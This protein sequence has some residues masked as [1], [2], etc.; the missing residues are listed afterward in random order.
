MANH[1]LSYRILGVIVLLTLLLPLTSSPGLLASTE[2]QVPAATVPLSPAEPMRAPST[3]EADT[4]PPAPVANLVAST[5]T[6]PGTVELSWVAP[7]DDGTTGTASSYIVRYN[8]VSITEDNWATATDATGEPGPAPAGSVESM[9]VT[10]LMPSQPY[11]FAITTQDEVPNTSSV[12]NSPR[13]IALSSPNATFLPLAVSSATS[14]TPVVP[15]T[16]QVLPPETTQYLSSISGDGA[17]YTFT[18]STPELGALAPGDIMVG[19]VAANAPYGFLRRVT[20]VSPQGDQVIVETEPA[21]LEEA[22]ESATLHVSQALTPEHVSGGTHA[23]G[24]T[25]SPA[26]GGLGEFYFEID[27]VVLVGDTSQVGSYPTGASPYGAL[28]MGGNVWEWVN[29]WYDPAYYNYSP[30]NNPQ[31][32]DTGCCKVLR[33]GS[34]PD[35]WGTVRAAFRIDSYPG[36]RNDVFGFRCAV[37]PGG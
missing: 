11:Y 14:V 28:D 12:S 31:G 30:D 29:D 2:R 16:T 37:S 3:L 5:G 21:T 18:Q 24:V 26:A 6:S 36:N 23:A 22:I 9:I 33:G 17:V 13:A 19:D 32:P 7:G 15:E 4:E 25:L 27:N 8:T 34:W 35:Y 10:G 20:T 1:R